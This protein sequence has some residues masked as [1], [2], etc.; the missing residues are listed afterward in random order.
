MNGWH[1]RCRPVR[2]A[3]YLALLLGWLG[4]WGSA[5]ATTAT[6][7]TLTLHRAKTTVMVHGETIRSDVTLPYSWDSSNPGQRGVATFDLE[8]ALP[9]VPDGVWG[10]YLP[11][12]GNAYEIWL[13]GTLLQRVGSMASQPND[14]QAYNGSDSA[15]VPH[16]VSVAA[17][18]FQAFNRLRVDIR[19]D[20]GRRGGLAPILIGPQDEVFPL[21]TQN[22]RWRVT[23]VAG[24]VAF[25]LVVGLTA[26][27]LWS[28]LAGLHMVGRL[29]RDPLYLLAAVAQLFWAAYVGDGLFDDPPRRSIWW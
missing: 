14:L 5:W 4:W 28:G 22:Y 10:I 7:T 24:L 29:R 19:A 25:S 2:T 17:G 26:L 6:T 15:R 12:V 11:S 13:N 16:Y 23:A 8:F 1:R 9:Q 21:Y 27:A 18:H 20:I 3:W